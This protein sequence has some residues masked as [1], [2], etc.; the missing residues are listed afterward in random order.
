M[1]AIRIVGS[2]DG[3]PDYWDGQYLVTWDFEARGGRGWG[4]FSPHVKV[5]K[6]FATR[7]QAIA[8]WRRQSRTVP[9]RPDGKENRPLTAFT[10]E[11]E[12]IPL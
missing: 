11:T 8:F 12:E 5:A 1:I 7:A 6:R 10:I 9:I 4:T 3:R 2:A